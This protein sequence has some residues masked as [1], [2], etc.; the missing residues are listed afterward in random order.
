MK[1][2]KDVK[3]YIDYIKNNGEKKRKI[4]IK[5]IINKFSIISLDRLSN[6]DTEALEYIDDKLKIFIDNLLNVFKLSIDHY[7]KNNQI[8]NSITTMI[9]LSTIAELSITIEILNKIKN[10]DRSLNTIINEYKNKL[11]NSY[12]NSSEEEDNNEIEDTTE[13]SNDDDDIINTIFNQDSVYENVEKDIKNYYKKLS[14]NEKKTNIDNIKDIQNFHKSNKPL[15]FRI[16]DLPLNL[17][18][19]YNIF[20]C[21]LEL[22]N[23]TSNNNKIRLWFDSLMTIPFGKYKGTNLEEINNPK[24][25]F[26]NLEKTMNEAIH[27]HDDAKRQIIQIVGQNLRNPKS[28]GNII[29]LWGPMGCGKCFALNT[30]I[31]MYNGKI[32]KVQDIQIGDI[33]MGDDSTPRNVLS[34][35]TGIDKMYDI[36]SDNGD[37]YTVN[38]EHIL[39]LKDEENIIEITVNNYLKLSEDEKKKFKGYKKAVE[40]KKKE[41]IN[42]PYKCA[43]KNI[44]YDEFKYNDKN[45]RLLYLAGLIDSYGCKKN[46]FYEIIINQNIQK[47]IEDIK[48]ICL[49]LGFGIIISSKNIIIYGNNLNE[50]PLFKVEKI[51]KKDILYNNA[52][53][54]SIDCKFKEINNYYGFTLDGNNRFLLGDFTVTHNTSLIKDG[55]SKAMD[56]P[57]IFIS[58][59]GAT[60]AAFLEGHSYTYEGSIYGRI[61][62]GLIDAKCMDPIIYFDELDK[63]SKTHKGEEITNILIHLTD[64]IQNTHFRDKYFH[65]IDIDLSRATLIFSY[66]N[67]HNVNPILLDRIASIQTKYLLL[68]QKIFIAKHYLI[69]NIIK[70]IGLKLNDI[71]INDNLIKFII[72]KYTCEGGVRKIKS[73]L[74]NIIRELNLKNLLNNIIFPYNLK[75]NDILEFFK[76]KYEISIDKIH[77]KNKIGIINGL[78]A[79]SDGSHGGIIPIQVNWMPSVKPLEIKATGN[80]QLVIK[81][82]T[83]V[84]STL[85]F[86]HLKKKYNKIFNFLFEKDNYSKG[87]HIH[88]PSGGT[89]KDGPSA[90][91]AITVAIFSLL[92]N[93]KIKNNIAITGEITLE[94]KVTEIGGLDNKLEGAKKAGVKLVLFPN[95][96]LKDFKKIKLENPLLIDKNFIAI[97]IKTINEAF[98]YSFI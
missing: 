70:D 33:I 35:G 34:L 52:L 63:I 84:A 17:N 60:D 78:Y 32:K 13:D 38:S 43:I 14:F 16:L 18:S 76:N 94:G 19:K 58:L 24:D 11:L 22:L 28:K 80:L 74:Y 98:K 71:K 25:L 96:N 55:I 48:F 39:C 91:T 57:F 42:D 59:G 51:D 7:K 29:G 47:I 12:N 73:L 83:E 26:I 1:I 21:Y 31:L 79:M 92:T 40:F 95:D 5:E 62:N 93:Q 82:S 37:I 27:G 77:T 65:G 23:N 75:K 10:Y 54:Y 30:P 88:C 4:N 72:D 9:R 66:N 50:I 36:I 8:K 86:N 53:E 46:I 64:P 3:K 97:P 67:P 45:I 85:A 68:T 41:L 61:V 44:I 2:N 49:S 90:G 15:I 56:K 6:V 89:P 87:L 69:P 81:E 20:K